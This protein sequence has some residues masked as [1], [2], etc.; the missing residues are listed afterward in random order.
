MEVLNQTN[1]TA[2]DWVIVALYLSISV[3]IGLVARRYIANMADYVAAGRGLQTR[4]AIATM[5]GTELGLVTVMYSAQKGFVG[6]FAAFHIAVVACV[7]TF[8]VGLTGL[9][10]VKLRRMKVLT[11]PEF[12]EKRFGP[13]TRIIGGIV[14]A[15]GGILNMGLFLK[16]GSMFIVGVTGLEEGT[17][18][19]IIMIVLLAIVL[20]YT[21][22]GGMVSV[23]ITDYVQ[24][25]V[26]SFGLVLATIAAI[27][28]I[29][30][31]N[32]FSSIKQHMGEAGF[33][34]LVEGTFGV[35]Y[36]VWMCFM[37]LVSCGIWPTAVARAL[38]SENTAV[39]R[40][41]YMWSSI[42]FLI[43][44]I[45]P[46]FWGICA[47]VF[48]MQTPELKQAF[49]P[50]AEG[51]EAVSNLYAMPLFLGRVLPVGAIG[52]LTAAMLA[53]FMS[54]HDSYLLVWSSVL[55]NDVVGPITKGGLDT[56]KKIALTRVFIIIIG[57]FIL[58]WG[59]FYTGGDDVWDY[60]AITGAIYF[61]GA[62]ALLVFGLYWKR[63]GTV[64]ATAALICG[65]LAVLGLG[66]VQRLL[67]FSELEQL[68]NIKITSARIGLLTIV[69]T[70]A[71]MVIGSLCFPDNN[72]KK[73]L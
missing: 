51:R 23:V 29:G 25:V 21:V 62:F 45:I 3:I 14:L 11:I 37:G 68:L 60:M 1:F 17:A 43:R 22:L 41:Q 72:N 19:T 39:V 7:V 27:K 42:S 67:R 44:F 71:A 4:L 24:F 8:F 73:E 16:V 52:L 5:T 53:A 61:T 59:L 36:V 33:N 38:A 58:Y 28:F 12:Y 2:F 57:L 70:V 46:Y 26:L 6:G 9:F 66:P 30:W 40:K 56:K 20:F 18:L 63:A 49:F 15:F 54:T 48:I 47:F 31:N 50:V 10:V 13:R 55:T 64:G 69:L 32:I 35:D 65:F 34:P